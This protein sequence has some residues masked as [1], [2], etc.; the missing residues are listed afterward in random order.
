M[1]AELKLKSQIDFVKSLLFHDRAFMCLSTA[2]I[3]DE[4]LK[5]LKELE[6]IKK[7]QE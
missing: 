1:G 5:S 3:M 4:I 2:V 6:E 7:C